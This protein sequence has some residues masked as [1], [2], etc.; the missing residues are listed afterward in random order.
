MASSHSFIS[1]SSPAF[2]F[3][4][5]SLGGFQEIGFGHI[6]SLLPTFGQSFVNRDA[7]GLEMLS[8]PIARPSGSVFLDHVTYREIHSFSGHVFNL[9]TSTGEYEAESIITH[10]CRCNVMLEFA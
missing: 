1:R 10:N 3:G 9:Q 2:A 7:R 8:K 4:S 6:A 5:R